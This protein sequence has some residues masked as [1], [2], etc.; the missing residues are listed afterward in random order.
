MMR[1]L[2]YGALMAQVAA[3]CAAGYFLNLPAMALAF[4]AFK[5][6]Q[7]VAEQGFILRWPALT[8]MLAAGTLAHVGGTL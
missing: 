4:V 8:L 3:I 2:I 6:G 7:I 1:T 5:L